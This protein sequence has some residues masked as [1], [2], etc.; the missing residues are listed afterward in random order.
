MCP[1]D[2]GDFYSFSPAHDRGPAQAVT[3]AIVFV[4]E[5]ARHAETLRTFAPTRALPKRAGGERTRA[6]NQL[7]VEKAA[8]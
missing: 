4:L 5:L 7:W 1:T 2:F 8:S 6:R 3:L